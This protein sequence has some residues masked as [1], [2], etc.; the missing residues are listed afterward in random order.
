H[1]DVTGAFIVLA[2]I[3][4]AEAVPETYVLPL[5]AVSAEQAASRQISEPFIPILRLPDAEGYPG[6]TLLDALWDRNFCAL[7]LKS[8]RRRLSFKGHLG[9]TQSTPTG[10][11]EHLTGPANRDTGLEPSRLRREQSNTSVVYGDRLIL[12][13][14]RRLE[15]GINLDVE[16]GTFL[17][18]RCSFHHVPQVAGDITYRRG[19]APPVSIAFLQEFVQN[20]G[21]A[22]HYTLRSVDEFL[23]GASQHPQ[24]VPGIPEESLFSLAMEDIPTA[25][26]RLIGP[27]LDS[28]QLLG[29]RTA[30]LHLALASD[31][32]DP[33]FAPESFS[34]D[35]QSSIFQAMTGQAARAFDLLR[36]RFNDLPEEAR[37]PAGKALSLEDRVMNQFRPIL[38]REFPALRIRIHGDFHLGQVLCANGDFVIIDFEGEPA[39][40]L[41]ERKTKRST[42]QDVAGMLRSFHYAADSALLGQAAP[43]GTKV[44]DRRV[45]KAWTGYWQTYVS[46]AFLSDY[47]AVVNC[48]PLLPR[49]QEDLEILLQAY[50]LEK[51]TYELEYELNN[52]PRWVSV[53]LDGILQILQHA[54]L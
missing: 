36:D 49:G 51:A 17:T 9:E 14:F 50:Q 44:R 34:A 37:E 1:Q 40:P 6:A 30:E 8:I 22:W 3:G 48:K 2:R 31:S 13:F 10:A 16:L 5:E 19:Q 21:D 32:E 33:S 52:R 7:L 4:Y 11:F 12:K 54:P 15:E 45:F 43:V 41:S 27:Y 53:P 26:R 25:A 47:L 39:R 38:E 24:S 35:Y 42:L 46:A 20:Q 23:E 29:R 28:A 18:Q